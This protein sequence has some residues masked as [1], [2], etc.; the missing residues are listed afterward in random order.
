MVR[1][2]TRTRVSETVKLG[3]FRF[4]LSKPLGRGRMWGSIATR[5]WRRARLSFSTPL[6]GGRR[7]SGRRWHR[8]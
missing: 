6:G 1:F 3:P 2:R 7:R 5:P 4:R 8:R